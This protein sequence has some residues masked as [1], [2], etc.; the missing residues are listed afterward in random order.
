[1]VAPSTMETVLQ[2]TLEK[3]KGKLTMAAV[4]SNA[5]YALCSVKNR[6][7]TYEGH[8]ISNPMMFGRNPNVGTFSYYG[9]I[10]I[11][12]T[13]P[14]KKISYGGTRFAGTV[15][16]SNQEIDENTGPTKI[17][18]ILKAQMDL[19]LESIKDKFSEYLY[20]GG[21]GTDPNGLANLIPDDP[22]VGTLAGLDRATNPEWRTSAY[23]FAGS[24]TVS[25]I[26]QA[27]DDILLDLKQGTNVP[28]LILVGRNIFRLYEAAVRNSSTFNIS[29]LTDGK[30]MADLGFLGFAHQKIPLVYD[31]QC[32][33][34]RC[35]FIN[36]T[37]LRMSVLKGVD[38]VTKKLE[39][40][41]TQDAIA[42]R[43]LWQGNTCLWK[44]YRTH[45]VVINE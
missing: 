9:N 44:A 39:S 16:I 33:P 22:T 26:A 15:V 8:T 43:V 42:R 10:P 12:Q 5:L 1:M 32:A 36:T 20:G 17:F 45:G 35:Y 27:F 30:R 14:F 13:N 31:E 3:S 7:D 41:W 4:Q 37:Y 29:N 24:L 18:D 23:N 38:M 21:A 19:L 6:V 40:P 11:S 2:S 25:N 34:N 28:D